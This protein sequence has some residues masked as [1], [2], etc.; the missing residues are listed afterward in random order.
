[1]R[2][3]AHA[4][5][6]QDVNAIASRSQFE[7]AWKASSGESAKIA[8]SYGRRPAA[9]AVAAVTTSPHSDSS[10]AVSTPN[11]TSCDQ[12]DTTSWTPL[13]RSAVSH[14]NAPVSTGYSTAVSR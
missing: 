14:M 2:C 7:N 5:S 4:H 11:T 10:S 3:L 9:C 1:G 8:A 6:A 12:L 13:V